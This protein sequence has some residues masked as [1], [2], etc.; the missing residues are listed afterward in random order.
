MSATGALLALGLID[1]NVF[2]G[3]CSLE[4]DI[5]LRWK[6]LFE[7]F[8]VRSSSVASFLASIIPEKKSPCV[9]VDCFSS[10]SALEPKDSK[11]Y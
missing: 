4:E 7:A 2:L 5:P 10:L 1:L 8:E 3:E 6:L 9:F 11:V